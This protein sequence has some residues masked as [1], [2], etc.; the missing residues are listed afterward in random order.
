[1]DSLAFSTNLLVPVNAFDR[2][3]IHT[4]TR[5]GKEIRRISR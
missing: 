4:S 2:R 3:I 1:L 5:L